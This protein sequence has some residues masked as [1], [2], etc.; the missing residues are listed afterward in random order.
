MT[1]SEC[2]DKPKNTAKDFPKAVVEITSPETL[3]LLRKV[4]I[5]VSMG[6]EESV[7]PAI[8]K[9]HNVILY[10]EA[11]KHVYLYSSDGIPTLLEVDIPQELWDRI[12]ALEKGLDDEEEARSTED[13]RL[14]Q[15]I[16]DL[17]NSPDVVDIV[18]TYADLQA[19]DTS[20]LGDNDII[21]VL[22]D[23]QH[24]GQSTYYRWGKQSSTW[25]F[26]GAVGDYYTK[27]QV[28]ILLDDKQ[29]ALTAG[30]NITID[31]NNVIS[32]TD[33]TYS[34]FVGT[35][36]TAA[37]TA[38]LVPAPAT[39]DAG[40]FLKADGTW[41]TA[42]GSSVNV[43]QT[44]GLS[45][46]DVMSQDATTKELFPL[47]LRQGKDIIGIG[48]ATVDEYGGVKTGIGKV[49]LGANSA[50][51]LA[52]NGGDSRGT[53]NAISAMG[54][55]AGSG[56]SVT[57]H[58]GV[59]IGSS[60][61]VSG[62]GGIAIGRGSSAT[63]QGEFNIGSN[64]SSYG[65][66]NTNYRL[67]SGVH[68]GQS[69]HDAAT[70]GQVISYSAI[71]GTVAPTTATEG[72]YIGQLYY[73][74]T[75]E[76]MYFLKTIDTTTT[77]TTYTWE[78][79]GGGGSS[80]NVVQTTGTSATDVMSQAS[81]SQMVFPS[82]FEISKDRIAVGDNA[83][84]SAAKGV[85]IGQRATSSHAGSVAIGHGALTHVVGEVSINSA[86]NTSYGYNNTSYRLLT[87]LYDPQSAHDAANKQY[88]DNSV[89]ATFTTNEWSALWA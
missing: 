84:V 7:P 87:G 67:L 32:A 5:P 62:A 68:D 89:P 78:A 88:V 21:R 72:K 49:T 38:G 48:D 47:Y 61:S 54:I 56:G 77:P 50:Y 13:A 11:N 34:D 37:G 25:T 66:N 46:T 33:T 36:G 64:S 73:D 44:T 8:G 10:Y 39:T 60:A 1:C 43:V 45:K 55:W 81:T 70:Y 76:A 86:Y 20:H 30:A 6:D 14:Q 28:D 58:S 9:Y 42:G 27:G 16:D 51:A 24:D 82:G 53:V 85:A 80:V 52:I 4:V 2:G 23:E 26:I 17:K 79:L 57:G 22:Q 15:E 19:Y 59:A 29:D 75:N 83:V 12:E 71:N 41:D 35:D 40:K 65:Y 63:S 69:A 3:V 74:T 18:A 31:A